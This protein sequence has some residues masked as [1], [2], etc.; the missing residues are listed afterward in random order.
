M[1]DDTLSNDDLEVWRSS[2]TT[3]PTLDPTAAQPERWAS[4]RCDRVLSYLYAADRPQLLTATA[5]L[6]E[7][8][9][10]DA[11]DVR[12]LSGPAVGGMHNDA[13]PMSIRELWRVGALRLR[14]S[15]LAHVLALE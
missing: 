13:T 15:D 6:R 14:R 11:V 3:A 10:R 4:R 7:M 5:Q 9:T 2:H 12:T 1:A 8:A